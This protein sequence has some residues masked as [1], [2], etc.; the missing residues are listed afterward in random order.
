M[1]GGLLHGLMFLL[2]SL[3]VLGL[4]GR[5]LVIGGIVLRWRGAT[6]CIVIS[7]FWAGDSGVSERKA[8]RLKAAW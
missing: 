5:K 3:F 1:A 6:L 2:F 4:P 8:W 7:K